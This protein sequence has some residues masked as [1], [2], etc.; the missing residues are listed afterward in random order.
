MNNYKAHYSLSRF[1]S[2]LRGNRPT[3]SIFVLKKNSV[4]MV[5]RP[6]LESSRL[7]PT[8]PWAFHGSGVDGAWL[9]SW[10]GCLARS[11][12]GDDVFPHEAMR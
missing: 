3:S 2:L 12:L 9:G 5:F 10:G 1:N 4:I 11:L 7:P 8:V 6:V